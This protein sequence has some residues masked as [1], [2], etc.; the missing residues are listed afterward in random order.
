MYS[1]ICIFAILLVLLKLD[2]QNY[3]AL[4][5]EEI[6]VTEIWVSSDERR[7]GRMVITA[8]LETLFF[9]ESHPGVNTQYME[10]I[11]RK[12]RQCPSKTFCSFQHFGN[13][14]YHNLSGC[15]PQFRVNGPGENRNQST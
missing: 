10:D 8:G 6:V 7:T 9:S 4:I 2:L 11:G 14:N 12:A 15:S 1:L 3:S 13:K 5:S